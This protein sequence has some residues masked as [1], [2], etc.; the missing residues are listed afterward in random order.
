MTDNKDTLKPIE[1]TNIIRSGRLDVGDGHQLYWVDWGNKDIKNPI[2][3]LHGGPGN[4]FEQRDFSIFNPKTQRVVFH[5]Q[6]G[7]GRSTPFAATKNNTSQDLVS[8][9]TKLKNELG[10]NKLS[11][12]GFSWGSTLALLYAIDN[13]NIVEKM[14]IGGIFLARKADAD[15]YL[16]G[17]I[18]SHFPEVWERFISKVPESERNDITAYYKKMMESNNEVERKRFAKEWMLYESSILKLDYVPSTVERNLA[19]F[20]SES[21]SYLEA[22]Y[23]LNDCFIEED[24]ILKHASKLGDIKIVIVHGRYDFI[25][26]PSAAYDLKQSLSSKAILHFVMAGHSRG[27]TVQREVVAAYVNML[28]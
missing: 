5:D 26:M 13:P 23:I 25:C 4:G 27:D 3:F 2:F 16:R 17:R 18:G 14:L 12:Y 1:D 11:L 8:D 28:F 15:F 24:Y 6:R 22:H 10:F 20:A 9:I 7:S 21:L 19:D